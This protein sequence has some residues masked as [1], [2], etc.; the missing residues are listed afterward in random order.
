MAKTYDF[1]VRVISRT[2]GKSNPEAGF[3]SAT[4]IRSYMAEM[5]Q[6]GYRLMGQPQFTGMEKFL[7]EPD[8]GFR[9]MFFWE[10]GD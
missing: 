1:G 7:E 5:V 3:Y 8:A 10:R 2:P 4:D 9:V 6:Q